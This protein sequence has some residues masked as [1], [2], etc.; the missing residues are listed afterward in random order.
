M[1]YNKSKEVFM[2]LAHVYPIKGE[3]GMQIQQVYIHLGKL[4]VDSSMRYHKQFTT[5]VARLIV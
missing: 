5:I 3:L 2:N 1:W 4:N